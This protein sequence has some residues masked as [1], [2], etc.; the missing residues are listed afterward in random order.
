MINKQTTT[1]FAPA[2]AGGPSRSAETASST[3]AS[4]PVSTA[5]DAGD[6]GVPAIWAQVRESLRRRLGDGRF[7]AWIAHLELVAEVNDEILLSAAG[8]LERDRV[9]HQFK[10]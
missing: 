8:E 10:R 6:E 4:S 5:V 2:A 3:T 7:D 9:N 1:R